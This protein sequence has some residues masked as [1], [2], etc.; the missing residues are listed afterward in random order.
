MLQQAILEA[1][2]LGYPSY[3]TNYERFITA[4]RYARWDYENERRETWAET[5]LRYMSF[6]KKKLKRDS[7]Y[8]MPESLFER[9]YLAIFSGEIVPSMRCLM[10]AGEALDRDNT[11][12]YNCSYTKA[13]NIRVFDTVLYVLM[14]GTGAGFSVERQYVNKLPLLPDKI[15]KTGHVIVVEDSK[16]GWAQ[17]TRELIECLYNGVEPTWDLSKLRPSGAV[18][19]TFGGRASGPAPLNKM[20]N[21]VV[22]IFK[23]AVSKD[24]DMQLVRGGNYKLTSL[25]VHDIL[26]H[27]ADAVVVGGVRRSAMISLSNLSDHR[28]RSAKAGGW[29][30]T[31]KQ[32]VL[33]NNSVAYTERPPLEQFMEE[34]LSLY[35]SKS[36]E[37]GIFNRHGVQANIK[38][39]GRRTFITPEGDL[40]EFGTNPCGE[41]ILR[42]D[43]FCNL[44]EVFARP[45]DTL[46]ALAEKVQLAAILGTFQSTLTYFPYLENVGDWQKNTEEERLLGVSITGILDNPLLRDHSDP[47]LPHRLEYLK[48]VA[49]ETNQEFAKY[50]DIPVSAAVTCVK[51][52]GTAA[53]VGKTASGIH[54]WYSQ[55]FIRRVGAAG[56]DPMAIFMMR[57]GVPFEIKYG[58]DIGVDYDSDIIQQVVD[59]G[60]PI[61]FKFPVSAPDNCVTRND[62]TALDQLKLWK[63]WK[64][65]YCE[66]NPSITVYVREKEWFSVGAFVHDN[67]NL[68]GGLSFLPYDGGIYTQAPFT[69]CEKEDVEKLASESPTID[70]LA[71]ANYEKHDYTTGS[72]EYA[73]VGGA[74]EL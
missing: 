36:G 11:A 32:R 64:Q 53:I 15:E 6:F 54:P 20:F 23:N 63:L 47:D 41:I 3:M 12:G 7:N 59:H 9:L 17:G 24:A 38:S 68:I 50:L 72:Q 14:C 13:D 58:Y 16:E 19:K 5:V 18:L 71:L 4:S 27:I 37:R 69:P 33:A 25:E 66:H 48:R 21:H 74:C 61:V 28:M 40:I 52:S 55:H 46:E 73:C 49:I 43:Q 35:Q 30:Y 70:W 44:S 67:F 57:E 8:D 56:N 2:E 45:Y 39:I 31:D 26:C 65:H 10:T 62:L 34:W 60:L 51:P 22:S 1:L 42:P 29:H